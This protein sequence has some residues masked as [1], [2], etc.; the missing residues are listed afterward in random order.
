MLQYKCGSQSTED[1]AGSQ[2][3]IESRRLWDWPVNFPRNSRLNVADEGMG[4]IKPGPDI[5]SF[6]VSQVSVV[7]PLDGYQRIWRMCSQR[8][9]TEHKC[10]SVESVR[11]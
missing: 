8:A 1:A 6:K 11:V 5:M 7:P 2:E 10:T 3:K 4:F 9:L